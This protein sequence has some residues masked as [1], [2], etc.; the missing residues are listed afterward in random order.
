MAW[1]RALSK[2]GLIPKDIQYDSLE[3]ILLEADIKAWRRSHHD[4]FVDLGYQSL[5][6]VAD[7]VRKSLNIEERSLESDLKEA[8]ESILKLKEEKEAAIKEEMEFAV[9]YLNQKIGDKIVPEN[10][11]EALNDILSKR[12][13]RI[14]NIIDFDHELVE[15]T[16]ETDQSKN[17]CALKLIAI[18]HNCN[19]ISHC[20]YSGISIWTKDSI[21]KKK[22]EFIA[23]PDGISRLR[24]NWI[25]ECV[26]QLNTTPNLDLQE[27]WLNI[28]RKEI[29][30]VRDEITKKEKEIKV[31]Q[32]DFNDS[33]L[34]ESWF[35]LSKNILEG[36]HKT[37]SQSRS[38]VMD[39]DGFVNIIRDIVLAFNGSGHKTIIKDWNLPT[40]KIQIIPAADGKMVENSGTASIDLTNKKD[41]LIHREKLN[42]KNN[43]FPFKIKVLIL[44]EENSIKDINNLNKETKKAFLDILKNLDKK[45]IIGQDEIPARVEVQRVLEIL[46]L[47]NQIK[48][49]ILQLLFKVAGNN[50]NKFNLTD[51]DIN[52]LDKSVKLNM[53]LMLHGLVPADI[54]GLDKSIKLNM[55]QLFFVHNARDAEKDLT[56]LQINGLDETIK[57]NMLQLLIE[58]PNNGNEAHY[59]L[60]QEIKDLDD[61]IK[62]NVLLML[63]GLRTEHINGGQIN[64]VLHVSLSNSVKKNILLM[65]FSQN[66]IAF[67]RSLSELHIMTQLQL[68]LPNIEDVEPNEQL[69]ASLNNIG[70][71]Y[72]ELQ[73]QVL[74]TE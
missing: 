7:V 35:D 53:L 27:K 12:E 48:L 24:E 5:I 38:I 20:I 30:T 57:L 21:A 74:K 43:D 60:N 72:Q 55:L 16:V 49:N 58:K 42:R 41:G 62:P 11:Y 69:P 31:L 19:T 6:D 2:Q 32:E 13:S 17:A 64:N 50:V 29:K 47:R 51:A 52:G 73:I 46:P 26:I 56:V 8:Q 14:I 23:N 18:Y 44:L 71:N 65:L 59:L 67:D 37:Y 40:Q 70:K 33:R 68:I 28:N 3:D 25:K 54:N 9:K 66:Q 63:V 34:R 45:Y 4:M 39:S 10:Y 22:K 61:T 1:F 36:I 15:S